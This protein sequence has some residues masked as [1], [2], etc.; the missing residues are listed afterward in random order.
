MKYFN[1]YFE[2]SEFHLTNYNI[3]QKDKVKLIRIYGTV[4]RQNLDSDILEAIWLEIKCSKQKPFIFGYLYR[5]LSSNNAWTQEFEMFLM[6]CI[7]KT[8]RLY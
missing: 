4:H 1:S 5:P 7:Q 6:N 3:F 2:D 8:K